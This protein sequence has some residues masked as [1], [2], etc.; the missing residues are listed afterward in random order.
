MTTKATTMNTNQTMNQD[1]ATTAP[2][3]YVIAFHLASMAASL[4]GFD[5]VDRDYLGTV[6]DLLQD[7]HPNVQAA[8]AHALRGVAHAIRPD[9]TEQRPETWLLCAVAA[10]L[11][12]AHD[13]V[14]T[15]TLPVAEDLSTWCDL[16]GDISGGLIDDDAPAG[17]VRGTE[18][19]TARSLQVT[20]L[21]LWLLQ[22]FHQRVFADAGLPVTLAA[23][24]SLPIGST[25]PAQ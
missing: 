16:L 23:D 19:A 15:A 7:I 12:Q 20:M 8:H 6:A 18:E 1:Q 22:C 25:G 9:Y 2:K 14:G 17:P 10:L 4:P 21:R 5:N 24:G 11:G 3:A 13:V